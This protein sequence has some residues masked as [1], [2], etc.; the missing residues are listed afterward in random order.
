MKKLSILLSSLLAACS[1]GTSTNSASNPPNII[2]V[3]DSGTMI[4][5]IDGTNWYKLN[6]PTTNDLH[7]IAYFNPGSYQMSE[8]YFIAVGDNGTAIYTYANTLN[9]QTIPWTNN[10]NINLTAVHYFSNGLVNETISLGGVNQSTGDGDIING[11][12]PTINQSTIQSFSDGAI[13]GFA[14]SQADGIIAVG[15]NGL[16][17]ETDSTGT[18][19]LSIM[20]TSYT[21]NGIVINGGQAV[22]VGDNG[23]ILLR[24]NQNWYV[25]SSGANNNLE[26]VMV[27]N[28]VYTAVGQNGII[29]QSNDGQTW[30]QENSPTNQTLNAVTFWNAKYWAVGND[31]VMINSSDGINWAIVDSNVSANLHGI[32]GN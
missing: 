16:I 11:S 26:A 14:S 18:F 22:A 24:E 17:L 25:E 2:A 5:S 3:G 10:N 12:N 19:N 4:G 9:W 20:L 15:S 23:T 32:E 28:N 31:G 21:L 13:R 27:E 8:N 1:A 7:A 6:S 29:L 30:S